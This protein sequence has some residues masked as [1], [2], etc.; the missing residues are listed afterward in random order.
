MRFFNKNGKTILLPFL[1]LI[2][3][4]FPIYSCKHDHGYK[5]EP[6]ARTYLKIINNT[7]YAVNV[8]I[9]D[10]P[11]YASETRNIRH[12]PA[13]TETT[14]TP[15]WEMQPTPKGERTNLFFEYLI[16]IGDTVIPV[17]PRL[18]PEHVRPVV[19]E[20]EKTTP[21][22]VPPLGNFQTDSVFILIKNNS[23]YDRFW[24]LDQRENPKYPESNSSERD[25]L[26]GTE[27]LFVFD[28]K[29]TTSLNGYTIG[30]H[31]RKNFPN[32]SLVKGNVYS[33]M[34][35]G[36]SEPGLFLI[37]PFN[38]AMKDYIWTIPTY[39]G[40][41]PPEG[42][43]F[44]TGLLS[45][46]ASVQTNGYIMTGSVHYNRNTVTLPHVGAVPYRGMITPEGEVNITEI[47]YLVDQS[48]RFDLPSFTEELDSLIYAGQIYYEDVAGHPCIIRTNPTSGNIRAF[49]D[50]FINDMS[51]NQ[52][53]YGKKLVKLK[54]N[55]FIVGCQ[56]LDT[57]QQ[58]KKIYTAKISLQ[59]FDKFSTHQ[60]Y[61]IS[62]ESDNV[63]LVDL[64]YDRT[65]NM[66]VVLT[67][68]DTGSIVYFT[69]IDETRPETYKNRIPLDDYW[70]NG[71]FTDN[72]NNY[73][74]A[75]GYTGLN[76]NAGFITRIDVMTGD[77]DTLYPWLINPVKYTEGAGSFW[78]VLS[79]SR[80]IL[81]LAGWCVKNASNTGSSNYYMPWLVKYDLANKRIIWEQIYDK[82][83]YYIKSV[84]H[85]AIGSYL[86]EIYNEKTYHSYL[87]STDLLGKMSD[88][89]TLDPISTN[90]SITA[91]EPGKPK[92]NI[93]ISID[94]A[95]L[96]TSATLSLPKGQDGTI[97]VRGEWKSFQWY[98]NGVLVAGMGRTYT[99]ISSERNL[100]VY[101]V[102]AVITNST[103]EKRSASCQVT[104]TN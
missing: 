52:E 2:C 50:S 16:P 86:L 15:V 77:V 62:P 9:N 54:T 85:N 74:V 90:S 99:F 43:F 23:L 104:I 20:K 55:D 69:D 44:T 29:E 39:N 89:D 46:R 36:N 12:V 72:Q 37:E 4:F 79:E 96:S 95:E 59:S 56:L 91:S 27:A 75:G 87:V 38:P 48:A 67:H 51:A 32:T 35:D 49:Y 21:Q 92:I 94:D 88:N 33:F 66:L 40:S 64:I 103:G 1:L 26:S 57:D 53:L 42:K 76:N 97:T 7:E 14:D 58:K 73:Y 102:T 24:L 84:H 25:I 10:P 68:T 34:F 13:G 80:E 70:I 47:K 83:G 5:P 45:S 41:D 22:D 78:Y 19:I 71:L 28:G 100:G 17:Y 98:V 6:S 8:Y 18:S 81:V 101:T 31:S 61:W 3:I 30:N 63:S 93:A 11:I 65:Y 60:K 82:P